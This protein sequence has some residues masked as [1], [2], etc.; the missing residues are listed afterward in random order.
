M[1]AGYPASEGTQQG[2]EDYWNKANAQGQ[3]QS[4]QTKGTYTVKKGDTLWDISRKYYGDGRKWRKL[5]D[6]NPNCLTRPGDVK[7]LRIGAVLVIPE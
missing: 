4:A 6:A 1:P 2:V 7:T 3:V 5:L